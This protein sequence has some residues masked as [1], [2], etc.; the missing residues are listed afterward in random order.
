LSPCV[1]FQGDLGLGYSNSRGSVWTLLAPSTTVAAAASYYLNSNGTWQTTASIVPSLSSDSNSLGG[2]VAASWARIFVG[3][4]GTANAAG[5]G[6]NF[7]CTV[8]GVQFS[9]AS[10][11]L[12][13]QPVSDRRLK[14]NIQPETLGLNF[15]K[16]L[17]PVTYNMIG[18]TRK[19]H[20]F[21]HDQVQPLISGNNDS[22]SMINQDGMGG[23][24]YMSLIAPLVNSIQEL[25][26]Q[27]EELKKQIPKI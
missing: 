9:G 2:F 6:M 24:D 27:V 7:N 3:D 1:F 16:A 17:I 13:L 14:E 4:T 18:Q 10:N 11:T 12:T 5:S 15:I 21:I 19:A 20:G 8:S 26:A 23:V 22:L 25:S